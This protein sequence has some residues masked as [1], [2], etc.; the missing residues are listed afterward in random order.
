MAGGL[1]ALLLAASA[2]Q[3]DAQLSAWKRAALA[4]DAEAALKLGRAYKRGDIAPLDANE[5]EQWFARA[6]QSG[7]VK[8]EAEYGLALFH[9]GKPREAAPWLR[10]AAARGDPRALYAYATLLFN[11]VSAPRDPSQARRLMKQAADAGLPAAAEALRIMSGPL[12][13]GDGAPLAPVRTAEAGPAPQPRIEPSQARSPASSWRVQVGAFADRANA[14][15]LW[16]RLKPLA[17]A[18]A[19]EF[20]P[21]GR[22]TRL[23]VGGFDS[24]DAAKS[25]C[26]KLQESG[27]GCFVTRS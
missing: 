18:L 5:A 17:P 4:G 24:G 27:F 12:P 20:R 11:G 10:K 26:R 6:A 8:G 7:S 14:D 23:L 15:R 2:A 25:W 1:L 3:P 13:E 16:A 21:N 9:N 22:V 19:P